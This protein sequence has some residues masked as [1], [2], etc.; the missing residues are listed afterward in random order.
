MEGW[1]MK[2]LLTIALVLLIVSGFAQKLDTV[3]FPDEGKPYYHYKVSFK[4]SGEDVT[5][6]QWGSPAPKPKSVISLILEYVEECSLDT[7][8]MTK[9]KD[10][11]IVDRGLYRE[12]MNEIQLNKEGYF[13]E[14]RWVISTDPFEFEWY[15]IK[16]PTLKGFVKWLENKHWLSKQ[17]K[18]I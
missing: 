8:K 10:V 1:E 16:E 17:E 15:F 9:Y 6:V 7:I 14:Y 12:A 18:D 5:V 4:G 2:K 3:F 11:F 13:Y